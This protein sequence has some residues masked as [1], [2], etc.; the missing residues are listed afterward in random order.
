MVVIAFV[1]PLAFLVRTVARDR[2]VDDA[3]AAAQAAIPVIAA[4]H[5]YGFIVGRDSLTES[6]VAGRERLVLASE[7]E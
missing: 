5:D 4:A 1:V 6:K 3:E 7:H 2:A